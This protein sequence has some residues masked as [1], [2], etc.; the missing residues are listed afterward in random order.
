MID[1]SPRESKARITEY[2]SVPQDFN[3]LIKL[4]NL[5]ASAAKVQPSVA[6]KEI[7]GTVASGFLVEEH[8][9]A[10]SV[11]VD[12]KTKLPLEMESK[13][14]VSGP[15]SKSSGKEPAFKEL[16]KN[17]EFNKPMDKALFT[18]KVPDGFTV[19]AVEGRSARDQQRRAL[20]EQKAAQE[21]AK[22]T[23]E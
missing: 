2:L 22:K 21:A 11:W 9:V 18:F 14:Q 8:G 4:S 16:W 6:D 7:G 19:D 15:D 13:R 3:I 5:R 20:E 1:V 10:Y 23:K 17:F 12:P